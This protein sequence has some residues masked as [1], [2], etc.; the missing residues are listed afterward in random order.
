[1]MN[2]KHRCSKQKLGAAVFLRG[3]RTLKREHRQHSPSLTGKGDQ[4]IFKLLL[5]DRV[6]YTFRFL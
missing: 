1:M 3:G 6:D 2:E 5:V 4:L